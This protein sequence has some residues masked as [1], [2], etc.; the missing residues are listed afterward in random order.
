MRRSTISST[1][2]DA[3]H[4]RRSDELDG[5]TATTH[6]LEHETVIAKG[7]EWLGHANIATS[8]LYD[9]RK[10]RPQES[11]TFMINC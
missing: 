1:S 2:T 4:R 7:Q 6:A 8:R 3:S 10:S 9:R 5:A 11:L